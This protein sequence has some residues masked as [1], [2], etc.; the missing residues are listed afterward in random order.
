MVVRT[1]SAFFS[2]PEFEQP[3][4]LLLT[5]AVPPLVVWC[6]RR[7]SAALRFPDI[8]TAVA[9]NT[10]RGTVAR[11][12]GALGRGLALVVLVLALAGPRWPDPGARIPTEGIAILL[13]VDVSNSMNE[14]D[15]L[16]QGQ[17]IPRIKAMKQAIRLLVAGEEGQRPG[18]EQLPGRPHDL[19]GLVTFTRWPKS[20]CPLTMSHATL[21]EILDREETNMAGH[22][23]DT[24]IGDAIAWSV[25][26]LRPASVKHKVIILV[27]DGEQGEIKDALRPRQGGQL[28][29]NLGIPVMV[30]DAGNDAAL[31]DKTP[32][33]QPAADSRRNARQA[34]QDLAKMTGGQ[35]YAAS[36][37]KAL[38]EI[39]DKL[40]S[41]LDQI[42]R[43]QI[44]TA[45]RRKF[46]D[47]FAWFGG[48]A[49]M[50]WCTLMALE[51][52]V[53]RRLP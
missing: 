26:R 42:E 3:A 35:Y 47:G 22:N 45:R 53:W 15:F 50:L 37:S 17:P 5:L 41:E 40:S 48:A 16:W 23:F 19:I 6:L 44:D 7:K 11:W 38:L 51:L 4:W 8:A 25:D 49:F 10:R 46:V 27:S 39:C 29:G 21:L 33:G 14:A 9:I 34:M 32:A 30:I 12:A 24:N 13:V 20:S 1:L 36:D 31:K 28:A 52:T 18:G 2:W 43:E